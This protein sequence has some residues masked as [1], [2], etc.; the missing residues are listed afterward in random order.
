SAFFGLGQLYQLRGRVGR[1]TAQA[2]AY[3]LYN[4]DQKLTPIAERRLRAIYEATELGSGFRIALADLELRGA[5]NLLGTE[6]SGF[7]SAVGFDLYTRML[8]ETIGE[9]QGEVAPRP[10]VAPVQIELPVSALIGDDYINDRT[11]KLSFYQRLA[12]LTDQADLEAVEAEMTDRFGPPPDDVRALLALVRLKLVAGSLGFESVTER[13]AEVIFKLRGVAAVD[14]VSLFKRYR[15][16]AVVS[17]GQVKVP[18]RRFATEP[19]GYLSELTDLLP[20]IVLPGPP[21]SPARP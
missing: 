17:L 21:H 13:D 20:T 3:F 7:A 9:M 15:S 16:D 19:L 4:K 6:Q 1:S 5:G 18:R 10:V 12:H 8:A 11:L 2:F 14:R